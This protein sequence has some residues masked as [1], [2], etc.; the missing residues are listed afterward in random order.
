MRDIDLKRVHCG[1]P[2]KIT[3][4]YAGP[5]SD[6]EHLQ[7]TC[8]YCGHDERELRSKTGALL[9]WQCLSIGSRHDSSHE[10]AGSVR[11]GS[12]AVA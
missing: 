12:S 8:E 11:S 3:K 1:Q 9:N 6:R 5:K 4:L 7:F 2:V 10:R